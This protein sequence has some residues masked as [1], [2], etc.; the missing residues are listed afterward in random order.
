[1]VA[2]SVD[3]AASTRSAMESMPV[4]RSPAIHA[5]SFWLRAISLARVSA[6][7]LAGISTSWKTA[8]SFSTLSSNH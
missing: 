1:M 4:L 7:P 8:N 2:A 6:S 5:A 3:S